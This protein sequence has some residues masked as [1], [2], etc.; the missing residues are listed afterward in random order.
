V[1][2]TVQS[3]ATDFDILVTMDEVAEMGVTDDVEGPVVDEIDWEE[4][5]TSLLPSASCHV[6]GNQLQFLTG[7]TTPVGSGLVRPFASAMVEMGVVDNVDDCDLEENYWDADGDEESSVSDFS[8]SMS[9]SPSNVF[10]SLITTEDLF[11]MEFSNISAP[12]QPGSSNSSVHSETELD[13]DGPQMEPFAT[14]RLVSTGA[15]VETLCH[16]KHLSKKTTD[17]VATCS[18][19]IGSKNANYY[20]SHTIDLPHGHGRS[21]SLFVLTLSEALV[22]IDDDIIKCVKVH[23]KIPQNSYKFESFVKITRFGTGATETVDQ[24]TKSSHCLAHGV[25]LYDNDVFQLN[26]ETRYEFRFQL[27]HIIPAVRSELI[28]SPVVRS[29]LITPT[30]DMFNHIVLTSSSSN[31]GSS[32]AH[33]ECNLFYKGLEVSDL[34]DTVMETQFAPYNSE[35]SLMN[36]FAAEFMRNFL[37]SNSLDCR[38]LFGSFIHSELCSDLFHYVLAQTRITTLTKFYYFLGRIPSSLVL[39]RVIMWWYQQLDSQQLQPKLIG[40]SS[41]NAPI[42]ASIFTGYDARI[43]ENG[44]IMGVCTDRNGVLLDTCTIT[45]VGATSNDFDVNCC[46]YPFHLIDDTV[47]D[48]FE[49]GIIP[50]G[51]F[52]SDHPTQVAVLQKYIDYFAH[53]YNKHNIVFDQTKFNDDLCCLAALLGN[54]SNSTPHEWCNDNTVV[55]VLDELPTRDNNVPVEN[56]ASARFMVSETMLQLRNVNGVFASGMLYNCNLWSSSSNIFIF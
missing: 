11:D 30:D 16:H 37:T 56:N 10:P 18:Y 9:G 39:I 21:S 51:T 45:A 17:S 12:A 31:G 42:V 41:D 36:F 33:V 44:Y 26:G 13:V 6:A 54:S 22:S 15:L 3:S 52:S 2:V 23:I 14:L 29:E 20:L 4:D 34:N 48:S 1:D 25:E 5:G 46:F 49:S 8:S 43:L 50:T 7:G 47:D 38:D 55:D 53:K 40:S 19:F 27:V 28:I 24:F 35:L 32:A